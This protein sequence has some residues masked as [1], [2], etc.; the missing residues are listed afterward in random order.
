MTK[1]IEF[2]GSQIPE[3]TRS[4]WARTIE[5]DCPDCHNVDDPADCPTCGGERYVAQ[6]VV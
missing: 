3:L 6:P 1:R 2:I 5:V 4:Q